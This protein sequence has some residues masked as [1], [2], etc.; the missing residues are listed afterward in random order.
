MV[1]ISR[2][3]TELLRFVQSADVGQQA[4]PGKQRHCKVAETLEWR[5][6][7]KNIRIMPSKSER[8]LSI[9]F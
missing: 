3:L 9:I 5:R 4:S 8:Y 2:P 6:I 1:A 7:K